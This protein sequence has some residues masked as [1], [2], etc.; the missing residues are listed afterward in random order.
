M[1]EQEPKY[2]QVIDW[3]KES[4]ANGT[5]Q[6]GDRLLSETELGERFG[7]SRQ[8]VRRATGEL[9]NE[10]VVTRVQGSGTYIGDV[11]RSIRSERYMSIAVISTF[12]DSYIFPRTLKG[13]EQGLSRAG[14]S[15]QVSF[16]DNRITREAAILELILEKDNVDGIIVEPAKSA[17]PNPNL[18]YYRELQAR[19]IPI[20]F[21]HAS[22]QGFEA[23]CVRIDDRRI[24]QKMTAVLADAGH[25]E[26]AGIFKMD[27]GQG[28]LRYEGYLDTL[29]ER[30]LRVSQHHVIWVDTP[31]SHHLSDLEDYLL[32]RIGSSTGV[33]C[34]NDEIAFQLIDIAER[35]GLR[36]PED[37]SVVGIDDSLMAGANRI[38][39]TSIPHP[40]EQLGQKVAE[41]M[42]A[43]IEDPSFDANYLF[44]SE[45]VLRKS[46]RRINV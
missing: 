24:A 37:L 29:M 30:R 27:D 35:K 21:F 25:R 18:H 4:I 36:I 26:I 17:L 41:N 2:R 15:M 1:G 14:Y 16:T 23:P 32:R 22:Y 45:P 19:N 9:V 38:P 28:P 6:P 43:M 12:F 46:V 20:L 13:I 42:L 33:V 39:L 5:L 7:L 40:K 10:G 31:L 8:T 34:Y 44:D 3:V 11:V